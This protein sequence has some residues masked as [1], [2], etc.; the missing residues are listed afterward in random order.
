VG[1]LSEQWDPEGCRQLGN[2]PQAF[3]HIALV[4]TAFTLRK[5]LAPPNGASANSRYRDPQE[6]TA[7]F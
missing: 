4:D 7:E 5:A 1:L 6:T 2:T 3:S